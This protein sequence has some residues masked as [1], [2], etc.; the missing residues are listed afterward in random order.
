MRIS[1]IGLG[2]WGEHHTQILS[3]LG[4]LTAVCDSDSQK[5]KEIGEKYSVNHYDSVDNLLGSEDFDCAFIG[6]SLS[7]RGEIITKL[8]NEKKHVFVE[9]PMTLNSVEGEKLVQTA[10][11]NKVIFTCGFDERFNS[12]IKGMKN[13]VQEKKYGDLSM[14][15]F[16]RE[17]KV[18]SDGNGIVF[19]SSIN[20]I[21]IANWIFG[22]SPV[23]VFARIGTH[24]NEKDDFASIMLGYK[25]NK[26]AIILSNGFSLDKTRQAKAICS[27]GLIFSDL[28]SQEIKISNQESVS[29]PEKNKSILLQIQNFIGAIEG[30]NELVVKPNEVINTT[31]IAEA[32]LLSGKQGVPIYLDLK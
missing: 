32:A 30:K 12:A 2:R 11:K 19:D 17:S 26:T 8:L 5:S 22:E 18:S 20:D 24:N 16:Y 4:V 23:V 13:F 14:L 1:Q 25:E 10:E 15:E 7:S 21:D 28:N 6:T 3:E 31:K 29:A 27:E 9:K